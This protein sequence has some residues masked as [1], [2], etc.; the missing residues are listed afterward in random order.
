M[1]AALGHLRHHHDDIGDRA[2]G[3]PQLAAVEHVARAVL[4]RRRARRQPRRV[5]ADVGLGQQEGRDVVLGDQRQPLALLL[6]GAEHPQRLGHADRLVGRE[7]CSERGVDR[8]GQRQRGCSRPARARGRRTPP[9]IFIPSA[10][11]CLRPSITSSGIF[12]SRSIS[13]GSTSR[14]RNTRSRARNRS[15]F[16]TAAGSSRGCG[17]IRSSRKLPRNSSLPKLGSCHSFSRASSA[18]CLDSRSLTS[19]A[20]TP[21]RLDRLA[22]TRAGCC[23]LIRADDCKL[24]AW[25]SPHALKRHR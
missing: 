25:G 12:A 16:S 3:R 8:G 10:P 23:E 2:V 21:P 22:I 14:S 11:S 17:W 5:R 4:G 18:T 6:L 24:P 13:S 19:K 20:T 7:Q 15:P 9:G 1:I